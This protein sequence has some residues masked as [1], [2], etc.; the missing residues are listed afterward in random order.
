MRPET[1]PSDNAA[2]KPVAASSRAR[3]VR[4]PMSPSRVR[5]DPDRMVGY[6]C[7]LLLPLALWLARH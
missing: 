4:T 3:L 6:A 7:L 2:R 5:V 1:R